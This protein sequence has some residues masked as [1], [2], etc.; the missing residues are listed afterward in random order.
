MKIENEVI[1]KRKECSVD[2]DG[3]NIKIVNKKYLK[4][5]VK[6]ELQDIFWGLFVNSSGMR[7][8]MPDGREIKVRF[9]GHWI[10]QYAIFVDNTL[11]FSTHKN[12]TKTI[13]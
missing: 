8:K 2:V 4:L 9:G 6:G 3:I 11:V 12:V 13:Q 5:Y 1:K 7:G 10:L